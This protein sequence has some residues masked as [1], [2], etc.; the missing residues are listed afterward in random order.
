MAREVRWTLEPDR[1]VERGAGVEPQV[2]GDACWTA[3]TPANDRQP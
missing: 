3:T 1:R 2:R